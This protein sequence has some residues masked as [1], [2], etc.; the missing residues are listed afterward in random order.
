MAASWIRSIVALLILIAA[1]RAQ[2]VTG[3][4]TF[5]S[6]TYGCNFEQASDPLEPSGAGTVQLN[7]K[8]HPP[9]PQLTVRWYKMFVGDDMWIM[10]ER[11]GQLLGGV[12]PATGQ[13]WLNDG[14]NGG[15]GQFG[16][17]G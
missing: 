8:G 11:D 2:D 16:T 1:C 9:G 15:L 14:S 4:S 6:D 17:F 5:G 12:C 7:P 13:A 10:I 3:T